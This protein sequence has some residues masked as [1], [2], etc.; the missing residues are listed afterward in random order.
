MDI[1]HSWNHVETTTQIITPKSSSTSIHLGL[2]LQHPSPNGVV[3][4]TQP[5]LWVSCCSKSF[6]KSSMVVTVRQTGITPKKGSVLGLSWLEDGEIRWFELWSVFSDFVYF[7]WSS[8]ESLSKLRLI[9]MSKLPAHN[10]TFT[11]HSSRPCSWIQ[12][13]TKTWTSD[14]C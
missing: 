1:K 5:S 12:P 10:L 7:L 9:G 13:P 14:C 11:H 8:T 6:T 3:V 2:P 4:A